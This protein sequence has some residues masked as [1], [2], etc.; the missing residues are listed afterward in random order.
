MARVF[1]HAKG[2]AS[3]S[4]GKAIPAP[5]NSGQ[6]GRADRERPAYGPDSRPEPERAR[7]DLVRVES[8]RANPPRACVVAIPCHN[9]GVRKARSSILVLVLVLVGILAASRSGA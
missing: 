6:R 2:L 7:D 9:G 3:P 4:G 1:P 8:S 5:A